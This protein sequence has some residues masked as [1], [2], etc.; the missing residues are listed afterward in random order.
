MNHFILFL[1]FKTPSMVVVRQCIKEQYHSD[2]IQ[3]SVIHRDGNITIW[4]NMAADV[5][6]EMFVCKDCLNS[7][8][9]NC[10]EVIINAHFL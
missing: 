10:A 3:P 8:I 7:Q 2:C 6:D 9:H 5:I 1:V 4:G